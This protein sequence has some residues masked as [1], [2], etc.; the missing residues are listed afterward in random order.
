[1]TTF[2]P[3]VVRSA[4]AIHE[5]TRSAVDPALRDAVA[6]LPDAVRLVAEYH[7]GWSDENG[8]PDPEAVTGK[9]DR[10]ALAMLAAEAVGA[11]AVAAVPAAVAV[12]LVHNFA[13]LRDDVER[14][15]DERQR[16]AWG[17]AGATSVRRPSPALI[18]QSFLPYPVTPFL[19]LA[20]GATKH[21]RFDPSA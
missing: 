11:P 8:Q 4:D 5:W 14:P 20:T 9:A 15:S 21:R 12:E 19:D 17:A 16:T 10:P 2:A 1:M 3:A 13:L 6:T 18:L 7:F